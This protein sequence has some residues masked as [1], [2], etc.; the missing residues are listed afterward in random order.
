M[1]RWLMNIEEMMMGEARW[2]YL[3]Y[4]L[5][6]SIG[7]SARR[8]KVRKEEIEFV[9]RCVCKEKRRP[10]MMMMMDRRGKRETGAEQATRR[11][12]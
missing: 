6:E 11:T 8:R 12:R 3:P 7:I 10:M 9:V 5:N 4:G 2:N 1:P